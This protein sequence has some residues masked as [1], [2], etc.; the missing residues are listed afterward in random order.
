MVNMPPVPPRDPLAAVLRDPTVPEDKRHC[1]N[2][3]PV[4]RAHDGRP[5]RTKG[6]CSQCGQPFSAS[7]SLAPGDLVG[8]Q[9]E[10]RGTLGRGGLGWVYLAWDRKVGQW[11]VL[12]GLLN[13]DDEDAQ[14]V[15]VAERRFLAEVKH[16]NIVRIYNLVE[17]PDPRTG[18][19]VGYIVME[20]VDGQSLRQ[21]HDAQGHLPLA[22]VLAY[23]LEV[24]PALGYLHRCGLL[25]CDLKP[26]NVMQSEEQLRLIDLGGVCRMGDGVDVWGTVGYQAPEISEA[27]PSVASDLY[28]VGRMMARLS[29]DFPGFSTD[30]AHRLPDPGGV[31]LLV[32]H[33]SYYRLLLRATNPD[34]NLRFASAGEMAE[35]VT[36]VLREVVARDGGKSRPAPSTLFGSELHV[37][38]GG[39]TRPAGRKAGALALPVPLADPEDPHVK[40]LASIRETDSH[41]VL[42]RLSELVPPSVETQLW[43]M[44]AWIELDEL[45]HA[46]AALEGLEVAHPGYWRV[47]WYRGLEALA[48]GRQGLASAVE[49]FEAIYDAFPGEAA[50]KLALGL[51][52]EHQGDHARAAYYDEMVWRTDQTYVSAAFGLAR[53][54]EAQGDTAGAAAALESVPE[55]AGHAV[56]A[57]LAAI[58]LRI[59]GRAGDA[60]L[61]SGFFEAADRLQKLELDPQRHTRAVVEML[62][63]ALRWQL[64]GRPGT[65]A[66]VRTSVLGHPLTEKGLRQGLEQ[67]YRKLAHLA[68]EPKE[69]IML[70]DQANAV[71]PRTWR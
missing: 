52:A 50:P 3:H 14:R 29:F 24:L 41:R 10:V 28:T 20:Y 46:A 23:A 69:R 25:Y 13:S 70:V 65:Q 42:Q 44:R 61:G 59:R 32:R 31:P 48:G 56:T 49:V 30:R 64:A 43:S 35:Q 22:H 1:P 8:G 33:E 57:H 5:G 34:P 71:R 40:E 11:V 7:P 55:N 62:E 54:R 68:D 12:K 27:G 58:L 37:V 51:C 38:S 47:L 66:E 53:A 6:F 45:E 18:A 63:V 39:M 19:E 36:G 15:A 2:G 60:T 16:P 9:Y 67:S 26:D 4:G 21:L 17:H